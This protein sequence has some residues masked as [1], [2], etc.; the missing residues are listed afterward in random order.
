MSDLAYIPPYQR[1]IHQAAFKALLVVQFLTV[2]PFMPY[3]PNWLLAVLFL[4]V[5][6]RWRVLHGEL[7]KPPLIV[8]LAAMSVGII[9]IL[10]SGLNRYSLD[11]AVAL[12]LLGYL[13]KSLEVLRRRD[14]ILQIYLGLFLTGVYLLYR[15][16][17]VA[18]LVM[19]GLLLVNFIALQ[20]VTSD[21]QFNFRYA[22]KQ[23]TLLI[24]GAIPVMIAG[25][26][27]FPR[28]PP[29]W[30]IPNEQ[31]GA[32]TGMSDELN[33]GSV[34]ELARSNAPAFRVSFS[35]NV[36]PRSQWYW[37]GNTMS[38]FDG[39]TWRSTVSENNR[40]SWP[41]NAT[42]P[43]PLNTGY[44][45]TVIMESSG[46][47]WLY[48]LDWPTQAQGDNLRVMPDGRAVSERPLNSVYRYQ[49]SSAL[50]VEWSD[51]ERYLQESTLLPRT[52]N[53]GLRA[54]AIDRRSQVD[55]DSE[56]VESILSY[57]REQDFYYTLR[58]PLYQG[59]QGMENFWLGARR[60]FCE[61]YASA[62][63]IILRSV[64][65]PTRL[66][67]GYLGGN[68][69]A[70][71]DYIQVRQMEAHAWL[72]AWINGSWR[73]I[74][75]TAA[76][77]P[78]RVEINIDDFFLDTQPSDLS[79]MTR[80]GKLG[81]INQLTMYWD[82]LNYKWQVL[83][84]DYDNS[85]ALNWFEAGFGKATALKLAIAFLSLMGIVALMVAYFLGMIHF[86]VR[87]K[88]PYR[89]LAKI[90]RWFG[91]RE[92]GETINKYLDR[93]AEEHPQWKGFKSIKTLFEEAIYKPGERLDQKA[94]RL[95]LADLRQQKTH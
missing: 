65:I 57:I 91:P 58:P 54:W 86:P 64:G 7:K 49:A 80:V 22:A 75:P 4:V 92:P 84:L 87:T 89:S 16:D 9:G 15:F 55:S 71:G 42:L 76:V 27:F 70:S 61:H 40:F 50:E 38:A 83:V 31:R 74:D 66:V 94:L 90:E 5:I 82:S 44:Q 81:L 72:E 37:R 13:L 20:A 88:E 29:L 93:L 51:Q 39:E 35:G 52:G 30:T 17:P 28:L 33:P 67:G 95:L 73:R 14:A 34:A 2:I 85:T 11:T 6:W 19:V 68:Y 1:V 53:E 24:I 25:Y 26:L 21:V 59:A 60:G 47:R 43:T 77:A 62:M 78:G 32:M 48:F 3:M 18:A 41:R 23:S 79:L 36:P 46:R 10:L 69:V 45:Y 12:C 56:F 8:V 63:A